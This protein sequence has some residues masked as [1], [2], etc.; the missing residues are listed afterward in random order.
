MLFT[1]VSLNYQIPDGS[2]VSTASLQNS[3]EKKDL[4][5]GCFHA[6]FYNRTSGMQ[7]ERSPP[8]DGLSDRQASQWQAYAI[9]RKGHGNNPETVS[10]IADECH[11]NVQIR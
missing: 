3:T 10:S 5:T 4:C 1:D 11:G 9:I 2:A 7:Q 6:I 8:T